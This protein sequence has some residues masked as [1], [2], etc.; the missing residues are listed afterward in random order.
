VHRM[1]AQLP[2]FDAAQVKYARSFYQAII[3]PVKDNMVNDSMRVQLD[4]EIPG[5]DIYYTF[6]DTN[7]DQFYQKYDGQSLIIPAGAEQINVV[8]YRGGKPVGEQIN[9]PLEVLKKRMK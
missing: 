2:R 4:T 8:T 5:L 3:T 7:P 6:D 9:M 1:E